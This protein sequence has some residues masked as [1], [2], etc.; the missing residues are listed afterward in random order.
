MHVTCQVWFLD[1]LSELSQSHWAVG[2][3]KETYMTVTRK[4][5]LQH[6]TIQPI[7]SILSLVVTSLLACPGSPD[8][9][10]QFC[11]P[12]T[13]PLSVLCIN[14]AFFIFCLSGALTSGALLM[15]GLPSQGWPIPRGKKGLYIYL[16]MLFTCKLTNP[17][18]VLLRPLFICPSN[19][20]SGN[21]GQLYTPEPADVIQTRQS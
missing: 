16:S 3:N 20:S 9:S 13:Q 21:W 5:R 17:V 7:C 15:E 1:S 10:Y 19:P 12:S 11:V 14:L 2:M 18:P 8:S 6:C 4:S